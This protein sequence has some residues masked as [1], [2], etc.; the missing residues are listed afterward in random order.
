MRL[1]GSLLSLLAISPI[2]FAAGDDKLAKL[3][4][5]FTKSKSGVIQLNNDL[6]NDITTTPRDYTA[7]V[8][9]TALDPKFGCM[10]CKEVQPEYELLAKSWQ[11][12]HKTGDGLLFSMLDFAK[13]R[14]TFM[15]LGINTAPILHVFPPTVG[16]NADP[17]HATTPHNF[18]FS[19]NHIPAEVIAQWISR[20]TPHQPKVVRPF[21]YTKFL[22]VFS[23]IVTGAT[24][25]K[26]SFNTLKPALYSRNLW[27][28]I[29]LI[30]ILLFT[31]GHMF[32]HI[33][34]VPYVANNGKG[35]ISYVAGGFSN[36]Y[37]LETQIVAVTYAI[38][39]FCV[40]A[41]AMKMP[42]IEDPARQKV[43]IWL[44]NAILLCTFSF[45]LSL[46]RMK[47]SGYPFKLPP[48]M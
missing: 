42:R 26:L 21:D 40:I 48:L 3:S 15:K 9:L 34:S 22:T 2:A 31:S 44:W 19:Q 5:L 17:K 38:L 20:I 35:G 14:D 47:N 29:S 12:Q 23:A 43:A 30:L 7:V 27:S 16:P 37:G 11:K 39:A 41:L 1:L 25:L 8:L 10:L 18:D 4:Q 24:I 6:Y 28:A 45:L 33:R 13:G 36:Q 46:F 32:N